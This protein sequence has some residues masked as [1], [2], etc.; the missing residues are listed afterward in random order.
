MVKNGQVA[1]AHMQNGFIQIGRRL[2]FFFGVR[3][4]LLVGCAA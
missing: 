4:F 3:F 2:S 1:A